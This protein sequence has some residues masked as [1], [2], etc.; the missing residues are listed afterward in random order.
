MKD[1]KIREFEMS[2][3]E[4]AWQLWKAEL[5]KSN[6]DSWGREKVE[7]FLQRNP[8]L[9]FVALVDGMFTG[10]VMCGFDG[11]RGY[12]YHLAVAEGQKRKGIGSALMQLAVAKLKDEGAGRIHLMVFV[13]NECAKIFYNK[14]GFQN[15][16][17][18]TLMSSI[19]I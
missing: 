17:D 1:V 10:T 3:W 13:E 4:D 6:D 18:I 9:S 14:L 19:N 7:T 16:D 2:D 5:G 11:R 8:G 15:R 12:V